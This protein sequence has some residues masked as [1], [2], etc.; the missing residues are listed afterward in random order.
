MRARLLWAPEGRTLLVPRPLA[1]G[2]TSAMGLARVEGGPAVVP[3]ALTSGAGAISAPKP[4]A[5][6]GAVGQV[7]VCV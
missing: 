2:P 5:V 1:S 6:E 3:E 4:E 7:C